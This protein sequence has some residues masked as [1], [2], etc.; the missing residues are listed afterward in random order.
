MKKLNPIKITVADLIHLNSHTLIIT[1]KETGEV[2][3]D[4]NVKNFLQDSEVQDFRNV[5]VFIQR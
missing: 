3:G 2:V 4:V 5:D 1:S